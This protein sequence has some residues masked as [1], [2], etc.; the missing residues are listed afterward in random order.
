MEFFK[1]VDDKGRYIHWDKLR[2]K[3]SPEG[4]LL[5]DWWAV[6]KLARSAQYKN[7]NL[8]DNN[9]KPFK[10]VLTDYVNQA[11]HQIDCDASGGI[12]SKEPILNS[13]TRDR[14]LIR[15]LWEESISSSQLRRCFDNTACCQRNATNKT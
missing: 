7:L 14:Y 1:A 5:E 3:E 8:F 4:L 2:Y 12:P 15:S 10:H 6:I 11:L 13:Q 9:N